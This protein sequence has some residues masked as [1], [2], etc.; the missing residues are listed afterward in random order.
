MVDEV[1]FDEKA[2]GKAFKHEHTVGLLSALVESVQNL[3]PASAAD[4]DKMIH[5][6]ASSN[7]FEK[8]GSRWWLPSALR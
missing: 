1:E 2:V 8:L 7:G 5:D 6:W 3:K 4:Y